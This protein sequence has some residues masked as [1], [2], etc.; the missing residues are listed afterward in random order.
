MLSEGTILKLAKKAILPISV[1]K[2]IKFRHAAIVFKGGAVL[3]VAS[4]CN[5]KHAEVAALNKLWPSKRIGT[6][7][8]SVR[9]KKNGKIGIA[10]PCHKC[11]A[12]MRE[13]KVK[14]VIYSDRCGF[15]HIMRMK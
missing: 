9:I 14:K 12:F 5:V 4:N 2:E 6:T 10:S 13:S 11:L 7:V 8:L 1:F 3:S 15:F